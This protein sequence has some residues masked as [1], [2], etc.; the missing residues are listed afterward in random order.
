M[1]WSLLISIG[2]VI[3]TVA[4]AVIGIVW[5]QRSRR[6]PKVTLIG[7]TCLPLFD[8]LV[9]NATGLDVKWQGETVSEGLV[10]Y[11][12]AFLND[13][14]RDIAENMVEQPLALVLPD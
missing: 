8:T 12:G 11:K 13:G 3:V 9:K 14:G 5:T 7:E 10:F 1:N 2:G 6:R 4:A